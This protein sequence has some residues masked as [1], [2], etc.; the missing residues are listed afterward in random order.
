M[1][2][3]EEI[4]NDVATDLYNR[5]SATVPEEDRNDETFRTL[6]ANS[7]ETTLFIIKNFMDRFNSAA[8][9]L[10]NQ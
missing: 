8:E 1:T 9:E 5:W 7:K 6:A 4:I 2:V 3:L 10:K